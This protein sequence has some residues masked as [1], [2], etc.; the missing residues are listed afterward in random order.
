MVQRMCSLIL[1]QF[2]MGTYLLETNKWCFGYHITLSC[3]YVLFIILFICFIFHPFDLFL[4]FNFSSL[5]MQKNSLPRH[6]IFYAMCQWNIPKKSIVLTCSC[7]RSHAHQI[8]IPKRTFFIQK[9]P[10]QQLQSIS[11][12]LWMWGKPTALCLLSPTMVWR[13]LNAF[14]V[15]A[16]G[17]LNV[18]PRPHPPKI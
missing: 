14:V 17:K 8:V 12:Q 1:S 13:Y 4:H 6:A 3:E 15:K 11:C 16:F 2:L 5:D 7:S 9:W 10:M 18:A